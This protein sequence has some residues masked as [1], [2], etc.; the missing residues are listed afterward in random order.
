[1]T[2][3][4][5]YRLAYEAMHDAASAA[6]PGAPGPAAAVRETF[7]ASGCDEI[8]ETAL[9]C[10]PQ[11][12]SDT[13]EAVYASL[14]ELADVFA[15]GTPALGSPAFQ[16]VRLR[17]AEAVWAARAAMRADLAPRARARR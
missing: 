2:C 4:A 16:E 6:E 5:R 3:L 10:A 12:M 15:A 1:M 13:I 8:R 7:R 17:H 11:E 9:I 14:R